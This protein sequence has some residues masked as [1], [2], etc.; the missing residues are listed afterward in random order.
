MSYSKYHSRKVTRYG[1]R[2]DSCAEAS[3]YTQ[4]RL[5]ERSGMISDLQRQVKFV[6]I[7]TQRDERGRLLEREWSYIAD[8]VYMRDG[9]KIVEDVKGVRTELYKLK[10]ALMLERYGIRITEVD[11]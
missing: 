9:V 7:Q 10:R 2:F 3:R 11:A 8:F 1:E 4:L 6:L 5:M